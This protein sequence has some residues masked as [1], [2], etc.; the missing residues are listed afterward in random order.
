MTNPATFIFG[1]DT[2]VADLKT[3][4]F[5]YGEFQCR[6]PYRQSIQLTGDGH[7]RHFPVN[8]GVAVQ[9][10]CVVPRRVLDRASPGRSP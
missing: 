7:R 3:D 4:D 2:F 1:S 9:A 5:S 6:S 8:S 10:T